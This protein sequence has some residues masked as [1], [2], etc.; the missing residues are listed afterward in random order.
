[1]E[2]DMKAKEIVESEEFRRFNEGVE[3][4]FSVSKRK[5]EEAMKVKKSLRINTI[6]ESAW[7][8]PSI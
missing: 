6:E 2:P 8:E 4:L 5:F 1:M 7:V 3:R